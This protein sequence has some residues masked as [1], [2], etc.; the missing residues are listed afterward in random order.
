MSQTSH[1]S[2]QEGSTHEANHEFQNV[3]D[4]S[5]EVNSKKETLELSG[6]RGGQEEDNAINNEDKSSQDPQGVTEDPEA[7]GDV[8]N[9]ELTDDDDFFGTGVPKKDEPQY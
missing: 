8:E 1:R 2:A 9:Q 6:T 3:A 5:S 4:N 7:N